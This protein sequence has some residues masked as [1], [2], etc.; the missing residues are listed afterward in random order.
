MSN[1]KES[2]FDGNLL[3]RENMHEGHRIPVGSHIYKV[4]IFYVAK[5]SYLNGLEF[6]GRNGEIILHC[7]DFR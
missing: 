5:N 2:N 3:K 6:F 4:K 7:G 1:G